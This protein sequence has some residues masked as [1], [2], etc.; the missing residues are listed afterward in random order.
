MSE[1]WIKIYRRFL[2]WEWYSKSEMVHLFLH[3]LLKANVEDR[4]WCGIV[5]KRGQL[6][7]GR[8]KLIE[9]TGISERTIRTCLQKLQETGEI[10]VEASNRFSLI[11]ICNYDS[12]QERETESV[13]QTS[14]QS[15]TVDQP[16]VTP[17]AP[18]KTKADIEAATKK[19]MADFY[20][21]LIPY[22]EVYGREMVRAFYNYWSET[23]KSKSRMR[24]E[25]E[26]TWV[27]DKRLGYWSKNDKS[28]SIKSNGINNGNST[29][30]QR[31]I[32]AART[33]T[34]FLA[35]D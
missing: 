21:S 20:N 24:W 6:I 2:D 31:T 33:I 30:E 35:D 23:N 8:G 18:K 29:A 3:L 16:A 13:Q 17:P 7:T 22:V 1:S 4:R 14:N 15:P 11:T 19:R 12:Y 9:E 5:I 27:L 28:F 32:D 34:A 25:Q 10:T 26:K